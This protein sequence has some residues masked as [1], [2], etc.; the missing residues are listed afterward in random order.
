MDKRIKRIGALAVFGIMVL[1]MCAPTPSAVPFGTIHSN[2]DS[3][4]VVI[5][6]DND[7]DV[8]MWTVWHDRGHN[9]NP[10]GE[11]L[12]RI[13]EDGKVGIGEPNPTN[14]LD[15]NGS[16]RVRDLTQDDTLNDIVVADANGVLH[17]RD[18][19]TIGGGGGFATS[20]HTVTEDYIATDSDYTILADASTKNVLIK[21]SSAN[22][23]PGQILNIKRIDDNKNNK[24]E[25]DGEGQE[26][27][28]GDLT[29]QLNTKYMSY[30]IQ[31]DGSNWYII[32]SYGFMG[33][34]HI[35]NKNR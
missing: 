19:T 8:E 24:V 28:D 20:I 29:V 31:S 26:T 1:I 11:E 4:T 21:L 15:V 27:I 16:V 32:A 35:G 10:P 34:S 33:Q 14:K 12:F 3:Y 9:D 2:G 23:V 13:Q 30:T 5:D 22:K 18:V 6:F 25:I 7:S 17:I